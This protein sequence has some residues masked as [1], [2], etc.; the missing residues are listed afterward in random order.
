MLVYYSEIKYSFGGTAKARDDDFSKV[1]A[2][3][4]EHSRFIDLRVRKARAELKIITNRSVR[5]IGSIS[6]AGDKS[7]HK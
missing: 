2:I 4:Y 7:H 5:S 6:L 3:N 1:T